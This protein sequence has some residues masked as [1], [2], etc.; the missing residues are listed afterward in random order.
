MLGDAATIS[1]WA[2]V[3]GWRHYITCAVLDVVTLS[4]TGARAVIRVAVPCVGLLPHTRTAEA[5]IAPQGDHDAN[6]KHHS[7]QYDHDL[8]SLSSMGRG[9]KM[10]IWLEEEVSLVWV[11]IIT[12]LQSHMS[13]A[14]PTTKARKMSI[15]VYRLELS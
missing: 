5:T 8:F 9:G 10:R 11:S 14:K 2:T 13:R 4:G 12:I 7:I 6:D 1:V 3:R 15:N